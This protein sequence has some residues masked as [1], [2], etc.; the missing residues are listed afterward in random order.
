MRST[1]ATT[2][3]VAA[4]L[5]LSPGTALATT[6]PP[7]RASAR[8][9]AD[10]LGAWLAQMQPHLTTHAWHGGRGWPYAK[11]LAHNGHKIEALRL[12]LTAVLH[13]C[14]RPR[15]SAIIFAI[16]IAVG[17][18][19]RLAVRSILVPIISV[20]RENAD[21]AVLDAGCFEA[22]DRCLSVRIAVVES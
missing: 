22:I 3:I 13:G 1:L 8:N 19:A 5:A 11:L 16:E 7:G 9:Q 15:L 21:V 6:N 4:A 18:G 14:Y 12:Y 20:A 17:K 2:T 10:E